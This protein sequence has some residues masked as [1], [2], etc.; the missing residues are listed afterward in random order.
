[1]VRVSLKNLRST[2][3]DAFAKQCF[4]AT[5]LVTRWGEIVG[6]EIAAHC[7]PEKIQWPHPFDNEMP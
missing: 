1:M 3:K 6:P 5:E 2:I 4:A 7:E